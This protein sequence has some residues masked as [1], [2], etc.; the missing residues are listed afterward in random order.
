MNKNPS[1]TL[2]LDSQFLQ[3]L[4]NARSGFDGVAAVVIEP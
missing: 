1:E 4:M 3:Y 2:N